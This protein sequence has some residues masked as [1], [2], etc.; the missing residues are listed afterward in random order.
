MDGNGACIVADKVSDKIKV[1]PC[2]SEVF[3]FF[4]LAFEL[5]NSEVREDVVSL[6]HA[7]VGFKGSII[8]A[9]EMLD[10][11]TS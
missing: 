1:E 8:E 9:I 6:R 2:L 11:A 3:D 4:V 7:D 10:K 5:S